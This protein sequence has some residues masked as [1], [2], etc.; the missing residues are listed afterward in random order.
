ME[1]NNEIFWIVGVKLSDKFK[2]ELIKMLVECITENKDFDEKK[3]IG[4]CFACKI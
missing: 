1:S 4:Y 3:I 2:G